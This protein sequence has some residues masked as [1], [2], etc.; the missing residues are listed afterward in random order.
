MRS[1][2]RPGTLFPV[3]GGSLQVR[4]E[5]RVVAN[6]LIDLQPVALTVSDDDRIAGGIELYRGRETEPPLR[7]KALYTAPRFHHIR[8]SVDALLAP[9][10]QDLRI[11]DQCGDRAALGVEHADPVVAPIA[12]V[13]VTVAVDRDIGRVIKLIGPRMPSFF[14]LAGDVGSVDRYRV[15][16]FRLRQLAE[17]AKAHQRLAF[18]RQLLDGVVPPV[19]DVDFAVLIEGDAP[20]LF[21]LPWRLAR[22]AAFAD[23]LAVRAEHLQAVVATVSDDDV[24]V[25]LDDQAGRTQQFTVAAAGR[26]KFRDVIAASVEY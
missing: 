15:G 19:G 14:A 12:H 17:A 22:P 2:R 23:V 8:V 13:D 21:N 10:R 24:A 7:L 20:G 18:G 9:F 16:A 5:I 11:A 4:L 1:L 6:L 26:A 25:L 3:C